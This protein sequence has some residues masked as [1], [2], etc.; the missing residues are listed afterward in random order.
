MPEGVNKQCKKN[1][2]Q[3]LKKKNIQSLVSQQSFE[4]ENTHSLDIIESN[5]SKTSSQ[6]PIS[7]DSLS[8]KNTI[9]NDIIMKEDNENDSFE[10][11]RKIKNESNSD[12]FQIYNKEKQLQIECIQQ[13]WKKTM[14]Q[15]KDH[16]ISLIYTDPPYAMT[17][18]KWDQTFEL[19]HFWN[20]CKRILVKDGI[21]VI[22]SMQPFTTKLIS[23][24]FDQFK[25]CWYWDKC[26]GGGFLNAKSQPLRQ[27]E[28]LCV[29]FNTVDRWNPR[30][31]PQMVER[32]KPV[33]KGRGGS[34]STNYQTVKRIKGEKNNLYYP[35]TLLSVDNSFQKEKIHPTQK[36]VS[37]AEYIINTYTKENE[38]VID[39]FMGSG[40]TAIASLNTNRCFKG[41]DLEYFEKSTERI[42]T[43]W[44][45]KNQ[46]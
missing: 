17:A 46:I 28:E 19:N 38:W 4:S 34:T 5:I 29:F 15:C 13:D 3:M 39:P 33:N 16:S 6:I 7:N 24:N 31:Y 41:G 36:P 23:S 21:I 44:Q 27:V 8:S 12:G 25:Y 37:L 18:N 30:Y 42:K 26:K 45:N 22:H 20:E 10:F 11:F 9:P 43:H 40:T 35:T 14:A 2:S 1:L 32:G